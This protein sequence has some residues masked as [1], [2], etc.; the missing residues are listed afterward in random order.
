MLIPDRI[1]LQGHSWGGYESAFIVTQTDMFVAVVTGALLT[2]LISM[3]NV[4]YKRAGIFERSTSRMV[5]RMVTRMHG[6]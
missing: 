4:I 6:S 3:Y 1:G 2:N 5:S